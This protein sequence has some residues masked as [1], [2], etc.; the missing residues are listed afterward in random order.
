MLHPRKLGELDG[1]IALV[2]RLTLFAFF[3]NRSS[4][5][6]LPMHWSIPLRRPRR[7]H[8]SNGNNGLHRTITVEETQEEEVVSPQA[9][10]VRRDLADSSAGAEERAEDEVGELTEAR[11]S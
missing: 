9:I 3:L 11:C 1:P 4:I 2:A 8:A 10:A 6:V 7:K 5:A